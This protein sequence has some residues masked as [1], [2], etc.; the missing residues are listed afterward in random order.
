M[1]GE[2]GGVEQGGKLY[3]I[4]SVLRVEDWMTQTNLCVSLDQNPRTEVGQK[5]CVVLFDSPGKVDTLGWCQPYPAATQA[6]EE[7]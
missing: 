5:N 4:Q 7:E 1:S 2:L 6:A 3:M